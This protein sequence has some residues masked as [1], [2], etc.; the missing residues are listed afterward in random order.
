MA[1]GGGRVCD[2]LAVGREVVDEEGSV[3]QW[4][5]RKNK[6]ESETIPLEA[7]T[8][9]GQNVRGFPFPEVGSSKP[10]LALGCNPEMLHYGSFG[11]RPARKQTSS[12]HSLWPRRRW[13]L[14]ILCVRPCAS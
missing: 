8:L 3:E 4:P 6:R 13:F 2:L 11:I 5:F 10:I 1:R 9:G 14:E 12:A 7:C